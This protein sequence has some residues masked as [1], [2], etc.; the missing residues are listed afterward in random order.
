MCGHYELVDKLLEPQDCSGLGEL[1]IIK[2]LRGAWLGY[3]AYHPLQPCRGKDAAKAH[4]IDWLDFKC[5][6][7]RAVLIAHRII[8]TIVRLGGGAVLAGRRVGGDGVAVGYATLV[9]RPD[10]HGVPG[11][12]ELNGA[13]LSTQ[14]DRD[15]DLTHSMMYPTGAG[16]QPDGAV[17]A[18]GGT[19]ASR[20]HSQT[21]RRKSPARKP[22]R[23]SGGAPRSNDDDDD[24]DGS[25]DGRGSSSHRGRRQG[26]APVAEATEAQQGEPMK[27]GVKF[28]VDVS[29]GSEAAGP[30]H[31]APDDRDAEDGVAEHQELT[32]VKWNLVRQLFHQKH[33]RTAACKPLALACLVGGG[34]VAG[35]SV[36]MRQYCTTEVG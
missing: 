35:W 15:D 11:V 30:Q 20:E 19:G 10:A 31:K 32:D 5:S 14:I 3:A 26:P 25:A 2:R 34:T 24:D 1:E 8:E 18:G 17:G 36:A 13:C 9:I 29:G 21:Q 28:G 12:M 7:A 6:L 23:Q 4:T 22:S 16:R 27:P 33:R